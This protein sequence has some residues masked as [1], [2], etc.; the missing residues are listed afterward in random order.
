MGQALAEAYTQRRHAEVERRWAATRVIDSIDT[1]DDYLAVDI[2]V[3]EWQGTI[4]RL[5]HAVAAHELE[6]CHDLT[7]CP[8]C[9]GEVGQ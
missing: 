3:R 9:L 8:I 2:A 7:E 1:I 6:W 4:D 5:L